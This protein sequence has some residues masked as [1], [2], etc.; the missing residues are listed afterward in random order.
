MSSVTSAASTAAQE[1]TAACPLVDPEIVKSNFDIQNLQMVEREPAKVGPATTYACDLSDA[2]ELFLTAGVSVGPVSGTAEANLRAALS[3][4]QGEPVDALGEVGG[5]H[6][7]D[8]VG[9]AAGVKKANS[10][11]R[12]VFVHGA[13]GYKEQLVEVAQDVARKV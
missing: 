10:Q 4:S 6:E 8:G 13:A 7:K 12:V 11:W 2:G 1:I 9:T 5:Y 3:G